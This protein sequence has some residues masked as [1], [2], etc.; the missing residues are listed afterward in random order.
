MWARVNCPKCGRSQTQTNLSR[1]LRICSKV[2]LP[3][4]CIKCERVFST[5]SKF[6]QHVKSKV[7]QKENMK[8]FFY[9]DNETEPNLED[10]DTIEQKVRF[11]YLVS[12][13]R[14]EYAFVLSRYVYSFVSIMYITLMFSG[15]RL[16]KL[17]EYTIISQWPRAVQ[18][19]QYT[20]QKITW[21]R[22]NLP[23]ASLQL[24]LQLQVMRSNWIF[25]TK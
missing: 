10:Y 14:W 17:G 6:A 2:K 7:H 8:E 1:H 23:V 9:N 4:T 25:S 24:R 21:H 19:V 20:C 13:C 18:D 3:M 11:F 16:G 12:C 5:P 15:C 22:E